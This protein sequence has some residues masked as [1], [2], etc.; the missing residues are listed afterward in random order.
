MNDSYEMDT[1]TSDTYGSKN[2]SNTSKRPKVYSAFIQKDH[3][4][5]SQHRQQQPDATYIK[6]NQKFQQ[7]IVKKPKYNSNTHLQETRNTKKS[8]NEDQDMLSHS[9]EEIDPITETVI[10][11][12]TFYCE[13]VFPLDK[14]HLLISLD[15]KN[16]SKKNSF[17]FKGK[18][19]IAMIHGHLGK[20]RLIFD[21]KMLIFKSMFIG[22]T[23]FNLKNSSIDSQSLP[24]WHDLYSPETNSFL[25]ITNK[26]NPESHSENLDIDA[27]NHAMNKLSYL[28]QVS[29]NQEFTEPMIQQMTE[30][31]FDISL[32]TSSLFILRNLN[33]HVCNYLNYI[34]NFKQIYQVKS[35]DALNDID[36]R[37]YQLGVYPISLQSYQAT[38]RESDEEKVILNEIMN[39]KN[40]SDN[41]N[42]FQKISQGKSII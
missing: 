34:D 4:N 3:N 41:G 17:C 19:S 39:F 35:T 23:G 24:N 37:F 10:G 30:F 16:K 28:I 1:A 8:F 29:I 12:N 7:N 32:E 2:K 25:S 6:Y 5:Q 14:N 9:Q 42:K 13:N 36:S 26:Q 22:I 38:H 21:Y 18:C 33:S 31:L 40:E 11:L 15:C 27:K 20:Y